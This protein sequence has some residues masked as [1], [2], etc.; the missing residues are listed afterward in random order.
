M[1]SG[2]AAGYALGGKVERHAQWNRRGG[3]SGRILGGFQRPF[4][5]PRTVSNDVQSSRRVFTRRDRSEPPHLAPC[6]CAL[7]AC[8]G[9]RDV[10]ASGPTG[11][12]AVWGS[13]GRVGDRQGPRSNVRTLLD[14]II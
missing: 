1:G 10:G 3:R 2:L 6:P 9:S 12:R 5:A 11:V 13:V 14:H 4:S 8:D 7:Y